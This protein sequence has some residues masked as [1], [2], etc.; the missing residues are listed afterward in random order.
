[1]KKRRKAAL[2]DPYLDT[3]GGGEKH[4]LSFLKVLE[5]NN[6]DLTVFW[7]DKLQDDIKARLN[8]SFKY[9]INFQPNIFTKKGLLKKLF[10]L[11]DFDYFF[12]VTDGSYFFSSA[13]NNFVFCMVPDKKLYKINQINR[14]KTTNYRFIANSKFTQDWLKE[15]GISSFV[16]HPYVDP[17]FI[18]AVVDFD[19]KEKMILSVGRFFG[20][21]HSKKQEVVI[22]SF[23][24]LKENYQEFESYKLVLAGGLKD[25]DKEYFQKL[26]KS[27]GKDSSIR[28]LPNVSFEELFELYKKAFY[29]WHFSGFKVDEEKN[30]QQ[31]E[32][33]GITPLEAMALGCVTLCFSAGGPKEY[34]V[35]GKNGF[36]FKSLSD[37]EKKMLFV[38]NDKKIKV[39]IAK[40]ARETVRKNFSYSMFKKNVEKLILGQK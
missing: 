35:D 23:K 22:D 11:K 13:Q 29:F 33:M 37:L 32:H 17:K 3:L 2:Y 20:H 27:V 18:S 25:E 7:D 15:W 16:I 24:N 26:Q 14:W 39:R 40:G 38:L 9:L 4:I 34:I 12:Y 5:E 10:L 19:E 28:L 30:P 1:M 36:L 31:V 8:V 21:L 6:F